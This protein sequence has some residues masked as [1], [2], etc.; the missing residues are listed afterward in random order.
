MDN[1]DQNQKQN[2]K[3]NLQSSQKQRQS[4]E[5]L[6]A[7]E[8]N[9]QEEQEELTP[10]EQQLSQELDKL[11]EQQE[12]ETTLRQQ[13]LA[14]PD[15]A[16][17]LKARRENKNIKIVPAEETQEIVPLKQQITEQVSSGDV[18]MN[19]LTNAELL[20]VLM[21]AIEG[22][23]QTKADETR[24]VAVEEADARFVQIE[25][26]QGILHRAI[27]EQLAA[28]QF[29]SLADKYTDFDQFKEDTMRVR[30]EN[31][32]LPIEKCYLLAKAEAGSTIPSV[33][34]VGTERP[35]SSARRTVPIGRAPGRRTDYGSNAN[36][37]S[38]D[39][40]FRNL[41]HDGVKTVVARRR[42]LA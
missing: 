25:T 17:V 22:A 15:I 9:E 36:R 41:L 27:T 30:K 18:K 13:V 5:Q 39:Q 7:N 23:I 32:S 37:T 24:S 35:T 2:Q 40:V 3:Q 14:D 38:S 11:K 1:Q 33:N 6:Q 19:E 29:V 16:A 34:E 21:P 26:N 42:G 10:R 8:K 28:A 20:E 4:Q 31:P 12:S